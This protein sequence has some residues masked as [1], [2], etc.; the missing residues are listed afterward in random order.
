MVIEQ[1]MMLV[2]SIFSELHAR[3]E[4]MIINIGFNLLQLRDFT[5]TPLDFSA[6]I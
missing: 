3:M 6:L 2:L 4:I 1:V 5:C